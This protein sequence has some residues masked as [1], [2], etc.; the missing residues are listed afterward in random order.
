M[1]SCEFYEISKNTISHRTPHH[2]IVR[3]FEL[4]WTK[5]GMIAIRGV[6]IIRAQSI[7]IKFFQST[8]IGIA[9]IVIRSTIKT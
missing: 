9:G 5:F 4:C 8:I 2:F 3:K 6:F 7:L 1:F